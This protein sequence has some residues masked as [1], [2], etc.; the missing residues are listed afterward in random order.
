MAGALKEALAHQELAK[1]GSVMAKGQQPQW[2][3]NLPQSL[4]PT[5]GT[6]A[7]AGLDLIE[8]LLS[9]GPNPLDA[10][11]GSAA[12]ILPGTWK[13]MAPEAKAMMNQFGD[14]F[15]SAFERLLRSPADLAAT[16]T[17]D[18]PKQAAG[19]L[20]KPTAM[21]HEMKVRPD[22]AKEPWTAG[23]EVQHSLNADRV[24]GTEPLDALTIGTLMR[25]LLPSGRRGSL[26]T[27]LRQSLMTD[28]RASLFQ[29]VLGSGPKVVNPQNVDRN[30]M[31]GVMDEAL[32]YTAENA[33]RPNA[34]PLL[35]TLAE[36]LG[37][38]W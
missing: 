23:H 17:K 13:A 24:A 18:M 22:Y 10:A 27:L 29:K 20:R 31:R 32:A 8:A 9:F 11:G 7:Q 34:D 2:R 36:R 16:V 28:P 3:R 6:G 5:L 35:R 1:S 19:M 15:P 25:E 37:I 12:Q 33:A 14:R 4:G 21:K 30:V 38:R 26:D